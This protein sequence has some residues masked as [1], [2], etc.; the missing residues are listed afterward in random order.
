MT[1]HTSFAI[2]PD[3]S[4]LVFFFKRAGGAGGG[5]GVDLLSFYYLRGDS[6]WMLAVLIWLQCL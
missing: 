6:K 4:G 5:G 3:Q 2:V 1:T